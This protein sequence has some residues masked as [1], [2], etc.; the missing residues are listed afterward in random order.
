MHKTPILL[1]LLGLLALT[2]C[3][4]TDSSSSSSPTNTEITDTNTGS[5]DT[6]LP[7]WVDY[8]DQVHLQLDYQ[9]KDF[10]KDGVTQVAR[11]FP[12]DGDTAH[13]DPIGYT[14]DTER[15]KARF[16]GIDTPESTGDVQPWGVPASDPIQTH[17]AA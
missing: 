12:I 2:G 13:F 5:S 4:P 1:T 14:A 16:Y 7:E 17:E 11:V 8:S 9:G 15:I 6:E 3:G 10:F